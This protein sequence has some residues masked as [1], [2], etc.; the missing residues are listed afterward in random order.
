MAL[1]LLLNILGAFDTVHPIRLLD[2]LRKKGLPAWVVQWVKSFLEDRKTTLSFAG[3][4]SAERRLTVGVPQG[5]P[6]S[7]ILFL[8]YNAELLDIYVG[9]RARTLGSGFVD[10]V[11]ILAFS[12]ST[13]NNYRIL[14]KTHKDCL[15]WADRFGIKFAPQKYELVHF[16]R[17]RKAFDLSACVRIGGNRVEPK[18][19]VR[20]LGVW[21]DT[22]LRWG[23]H[24]RQI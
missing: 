9:L 13:T 8:F 17:R 21:L 7:L 14:E 24:V 6:L 20:V 22:R 19:D 3:E 18:A 12:Q 1:L 10:D 4:K 2:E 16:T 15:E 23:A 5:S 11:N